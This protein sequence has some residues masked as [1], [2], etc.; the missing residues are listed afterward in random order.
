MKT[1]FTLLILAVNF[2]CTEKTGTVLDAGTEITTL[3]L[4]SE[5]REKFIITYQFPKACENIPEDFDEVLKKLV[6][7]ARQN[8]ICRDN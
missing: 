2:S 4:E 8:S 3:K 5:D 7:E 6:E 1:F